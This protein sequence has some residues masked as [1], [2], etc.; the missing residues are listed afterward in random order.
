MYRN[1][2]IPVDGSDQSRRAIRLGVEL[3]RRSGGSAELINV[4]VP[5]RAGDELRAAGLSPAVKLAG[6]EE[7]EMS[8]R[9]EAARLANEGVQATAT[10][11]DGPVPSALAEHIEASSADLIVMGSHDPGRVE[12]AL[13]G[14]VAEKLIRHVHKPILLLRHDASTPTIRRIL[15]PLDGSDFADRILP[16][17]VTLA[18]AFNAEIVLLTIVI[19]IMAAASAGL[20]EPVLG[21][22]A[23]VGMLATDD[24]SI[25]LQREWIGATAEK[26][27]SEGVTVTEHVEVHGNPG[28]SIVD[29]ARQH[30]I[31]VIAMCTHGRGAVKRLITGSVATHVLHHGHTTMLVYNPTPA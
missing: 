6:L 24:E 20:G 23:P 13:V 15:V 19:P 18:S 2:T 22:A 21:L 16:H 11:L 29:Y 31:D 12:R 27:R 26:L 7:A 3:V 28:P 9:E 4:A 5:A 1:I 10:V 8:L 17:A 30:S 25:T 14:S